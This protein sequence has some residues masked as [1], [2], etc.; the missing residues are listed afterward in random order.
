ML[1]RMKALRG[2]SV[3]L[4]DVDLSQVIPTTALMLYLI[5]VRLINWTG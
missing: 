3:N 5:F 2:H 4:S 1:D